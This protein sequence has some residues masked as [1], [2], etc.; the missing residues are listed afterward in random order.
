MDKVLKQRLIGATILIAL[1]VIFVPMLFDAP[2][3]R[4]ARELTIELP[5]A[6]GDRAPVRRLPLDP[7]QARR[8]ASE[9]TAEAPGRFV[10]ETPVVVQS[11]AEEIRLESLPEPDPEPLPELDVVTYEPE[12]A[13]DPE[14][15]PITEPITETVP[16]PRSEPSLP[17]QETAPAAVEA[18]LTAW[19]VQVASFGSRQAASEVVERLG[20]LGHLAGIDPLVRGETTLYR[21][22]AGPYAAREDAERA[23]TQIVQTV[24]GVDPIVRSGPVPTDLAAP[25]VEGGVAYAAQVGSFASRSNAVRLRDQIQSHD[26]PGFLHEDQAGSRTIWRVRIGPVGSRSEAEAL[27]AQVADRMGLEGLVVSHP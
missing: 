19:L 15:E 13:P 20:R 7:D 25:G 21:V 23:R 11:P 26:L 9:S 10:P 22:V 27:L 24:A 3:D 17:R 1:A 5:D 4:P 6:P 18:A 16:V 12:K 14:P 2:D 8:V